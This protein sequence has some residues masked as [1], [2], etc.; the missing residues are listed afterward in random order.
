MRGRRDRRD[1]AGRR[2]RCRRLLAFAVIIQYSVSFVLS[3]YLLFLVSRPGPSFPDD[4]R[5]F[6]PRM[7]FL[8]MFFPF[9]L[10]RFFQHFSL[11]SFRVIP[12]FVVR[13]SFFFF[14]SCRPSFPP[15][16]AFSF[17]VRPRVIG[18]FLPVHYFLRYFFFIIV[19][20]LLASLYR[21]SS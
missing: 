9:C 11:P 5:L 13:L 18:L 3:S 14:F 1:R 2:S 8:I 7:M 19:C 6:F 4:V 17:P 20:T 15:F 10:I 16:L 21:P 12:I